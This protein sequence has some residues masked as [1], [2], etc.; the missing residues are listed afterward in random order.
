MSRLNILN[1]PLWLKLLLGIGLTLALP[2]VLIVVALSGNVNRLLFEEVRTRLIEDGGQQYELIN[3]SLVTAHE[4]FASLTEETSFQASLVTIMDEDANFQQINAVAGEIQQILVAASE[5]EAMQ[6]IRADGEILAYITSQGVNYGLGSDPDNLALVRARSAALQGIDLTTFVFEQAGMRNVDLLYTLRDAN[7]E[8][9][10]F[11]VGE[12]DLEHTFKRYLEVPGSGDVV[13]VYN[14]LATVGQTP[15]VIAA[16]TDDRSALTPSSGNSPGKIFALDGQ[17]GVSVYRIGEGRSVEVVGYYSPIYDPASP[18]NILFALVYEIPTSG[19]G[20]ENFIRTVAAPNAFV[21]VITALILVPLVVLFLSQTIAPQLLNLREALHGV[22]KGDFN[23]PVHAAHRRDEV[24]QLAA[25]VIDMRSHVQGVMSELEARVAVNARDIS[26]TQE[27]SRYAATER[28]LQTL[29]KQVVNL[30]AEKYPTIYYAQIFLVDAERE[31]AVLGASTGEVGDILLRRGHRL[32][33]GSNSIVGQVAGQG[34]TVVVRDVTT[35]AIHK[36]NPL[37]PDTRAELAI[38]L[39]IGEQIIGVLDVQSKS[40]GVFS[41]YEVLILSTM[42]DQVAVAIENAR[43]YQESIRRLE[44]VERFNRESTLRTWRE[45][46]YGQR[47]RELTS[48][49]GVQSDRDSSDL[50]QRAQAE[51]RIVLGEQTTHGTIPLAVPIQLRGVTLGAVEWEIPA[52]DLNDNKL[53]LAQELANRL[54]IGLDNARLFQESQ[55][56]AERE[57][58]VNSI[59][60]KLTP[61]TE[62]SDILQTAVREVG[63]ALRV[64]QVSIRL[65]NGNG[66]GNGHSNGAS[67]NGHHN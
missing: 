1:W 42:A 50:R 32:V 56:N 25:T 36:P 8:P 10:G 26:A 51:G 27:V 3:D 48:Q 7:D 55:R 60:T 44:E 64:P 62:I 9:V 38:P 58:I 15:V 23:R 34:R 5:F 14:Y 63:Q 67:A 40:S 19:I 11:L 24:G 4:I 57:R 49:A 45:Y 2:V 31:N 65:H 66:N 39:R 43:L 47:A 18:E 13:Q 20:T 22:I 30:I 17:E 33:V 53:Q 35:S 37:L 41:E 52:K 21:F 16:D 59:A 6:L 61:Q 28:N 54:A 46:T 29:M 12:L